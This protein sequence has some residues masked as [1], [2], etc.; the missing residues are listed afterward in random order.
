QKLLDEGWLKDEHRGRLRN[1]HIHS[2]RSDKA[3]IDLS[4]ATKFNVELPFLKDLKERGRRIAD[5]W[6]EETY[7]DIG[8][9]SSVDIRAMFDSE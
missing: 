7:E 6:I 9:R 1:I 2:V 3:L 8:K 5:A 4:V